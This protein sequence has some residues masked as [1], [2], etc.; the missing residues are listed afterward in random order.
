M[1]RLVR[2]FLAI[3]LSEPRGQAPAWWF[4]EQPRKFRDDRPRRADPHPAASRP[5]LPPGEGRPPRKMEDAA[6][7]G[8]PRLLFAEA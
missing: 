1:R 7:R 8:W 6:E 5:L 4:R 2:R 3:G